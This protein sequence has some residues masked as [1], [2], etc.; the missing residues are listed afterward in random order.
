MIERTSARRCAQR[1]RVTA[2]RGRWP[3]RRSLEPLDLAGRAKLLRIARDVA[4]ATERQNAPLAAFLIGRFVRGLDPL[5][6][7]AG[8]RPRR[9][10]VSRSGPS[11]GR[12]LTDLR[13]VA[14][15]VEVAGES[16]REAGV[17][18]LA[19]RKPE[20]VRSLDQP[21]Q[22]SVPSRRGRSP[23][24]RGVTS[25]RPHGAAGCPGSSR[26]PRRRARRFWRRSILMS[27]GSI[28]GRSTATTA[29][30]LCGEARKAATSPPSG[31]APRTASGMKCR[32]A[33]VRG[34][35]PAA[36][37]TGSHTGVEA[38]ERATKQSH[39]FEGERRLVDAHPRAP[40]AAQNDAGEGRARMR[41]AGSQPRRR[42][43]RVATPLGATLR[44][45]PRSRN[46]ERSSDLCAGAGSSPR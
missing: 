4:H 9:G 40:T 11:S 15:R 33:I 10:G 31:P 12:M 43:V 29:S 13:E 6:Y 45:S 37:S 14:G 2:E 34:T 26:T 18:P 20:R 30:S 22:R 23:R 32:P 41:T 24:L 17:A 35:S 39:A 44:K 27:I 1:A 8:R 25:S 7:L 19:L 3:R 38:R 21:P 36:M 16:V 42:Q 5:G 46:S 28:H